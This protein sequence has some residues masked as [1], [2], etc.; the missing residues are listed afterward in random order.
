MA[1]IQTYMVGALLS[2][3]KTIY[4]I[5]EPNLKRDRPLE[6]LCLGL[7]RSAT[8]SLS[9]ALVHLG[10]DDCYHG[11]QI[12]SH[13]V[14]DSPQWYRLANAKITRTTTL[15]CAEEFDSVLG[16]CMAVTDAPCC[17]FGEELVRCY[18]SAKVILNRRRDVEAWEES[19]KATLFGIYSSWWRFARAF[20]LTDLFW[21]WLWT[22][23]VMGPMMMTELERNPNRM[24]E[25]YEKHYDDLKKVCRVQ[26]REYLEWSVEDG[27]EP[28]CQFL[29]KP[30]P[31]D[32]FPAGNSVTDF[33]D[34]KTRI[35]DPRL[36][37][38]ERNMMLTAVVTLGLS[39]AFFTTY[40]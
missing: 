35:Q 32:P 40:Q 24:G 11:L 33:Q 7:S 2:L 34:F 3:L 30:V 19:V 15:L 22:C 1:T 25:I 29:D 18:P 12:V 13:R 4:P 9:K 10:Y 6:V 14:S 38:A 20:F 31:D 36:R 27:W 28:L 5:R 8:E 16:H 17:C 21:L 39:L 26:G 23:G 37:K